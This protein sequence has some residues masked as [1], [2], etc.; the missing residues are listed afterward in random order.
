MK[1]SNLMLLE[2]QLEDHIAGNLL[3]TLFSHHFE[4]DGVAIPHSLLNVHMESRGLRKKPWCTRN[5]IVMIGI[6]CNYYQFRKYSNSYTSIINGFFESNTFNWLDCKDPVTNENIFW[7]IS[8]TSR[9]VATHLCIG[10][11]TKTKIESDEG[12]TMM[13]LKYE[14]IN[15]N[16][17]KIAISDSTCVCVNLQIP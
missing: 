3:W 11:P 4:C 15:G 2:L 8:C 1:S 6:R 9:L 10:S 5:G 17:E 13:L 16:D 12:Y 7:L 14:A